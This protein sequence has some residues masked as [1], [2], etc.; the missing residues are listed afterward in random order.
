M[1][2]YLDECYHFIDNLEFIFETSRLTKSV[3]QD[4]QWYISRRYGIVLLENNIIDIIL[5]CA[6]TSH[7]Q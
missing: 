5:I 3:A 2:D 6:C 1:N 4:G 7:S